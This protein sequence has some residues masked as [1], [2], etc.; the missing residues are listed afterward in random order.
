MLTRIFDPFFTTKRTGTGL[1]LSISRESL[2][3]MGRIEVDSE[4]GRGTITVWL[5]TTREPKHSPPFLVTT[6]SEG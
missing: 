4:V 2:E 5:A 3:R 6:T 1:G